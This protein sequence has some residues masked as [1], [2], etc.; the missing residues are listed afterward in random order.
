MLN[1]LADIF[2]KVIN[3]FYKKGITIML[4]DNPSTAYCCGD[5][6]VLP[7]PLLKKFS[8]QRLPRFT[9]MYHELG[10]ALY[11]HDLTYLLSKWENLPIKNNV[12]AFNQKYMHLINWI[13][14]F[15]I[16]KMLVK[17]YPF[18]SDILW[19]L[20][21][22]KV[23]YNIEDLDKAFNYYYKK[24]KASTSLSLQDQLTFTNYIN[25]LITLRSA[26]SFGRGPI[27]MLSAKS[28]E[29]QFVKLITEFYKWC[30]DKNIFKDNTTLP[31]LSNPNNT[32]SI[33]SISN[34]CKP[35]SDNAIPNPND[36][37]S[38]DT[39]SNDT[40][41]INKLI[42]DTLS[43]N[44]TRDG[45]YSDHSH[46]I[47]VTETVPNYD[48]KE[49]EIFSDKF[50]AE[51]K[52]IKE[53]IM[54][55]ARVDSVH[56]SL[57]GLFNSLFKPTSIIQSKIIVP[58]FFNPNRLLDQVLFKTPAK[59]FN[60]VSIYRDISGSTYGNCFT[61]INNICKY[62]NEKIPIAY[63]F[64][65][66]ASGPI[67]ILQTEFEDW[68][69]MYYVPARYDNDPIFNQ[70]GRG[71]NSSAIADVISSQLNDKWLNIIITDGDLYDLM[72]RD[73]IEA[74]L[75]NVFVIFVEEDLRYIKDCPNH[76]VIKDESDIPLITNA[77]IN[78]K[79]V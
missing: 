37:L 16:E 42:T 11:S 35:I 40:V 50:V 4:S 67:S 23:D 13:E 17:D 78:M 2:E 26:N 15:Y 62:L 3:N 58:N 76:I 70:L 27:S 71:T 66:Y 46:I 1:Y 69:D 65:L 59:S 60:N 6:I 64:Y 25:R 61:L 7:K 48:P 79:G 54:N 5:E 52:L 75:Q 8:K 68:D 28:K 34:D 57:D 29:T 74:L 33:T 21:A 18:L 24:N 77:L 38:N 36:T 9:V 12:Y 63:N 44:I 55:Q 47:G 73:N 22:L 10:H 19:C 41:D 45:S 31:P 56:E 49:T 53:E 14:D 43:N 30:V 39:L 72:Q 32:I 51:E 20:K